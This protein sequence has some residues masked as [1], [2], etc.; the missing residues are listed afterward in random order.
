MIRN[1]LPSPAPSRPSIV[2]A[3]DPNLQGRVPTK[4]P[5]SFPR[6]P[7]MNIS[8]NVWRCRCILF[9]GVV[10]YV[11][12]HR[13]I[14]VHISY[15]VQYNSTNRIAAT[16][17]KHSQNIHGKDSKVPSLPSSFHRSSDSS[18]LGGTC[19]Q[20]ILGLD[21]KDSWM[22]DVSIHFIWC[23]C[24]SSKELYIHSSIRNRYK[25]SLTFQITPPSLTIPKNPCVFPMG[26]LCCARR[27]LDCQW[28]ES[29]HLSEGY[30]PHVAGRCDANGFH[31][32]YSDTINWM[33]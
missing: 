24:V 3:Q 1:G 21:V 9:D 18:P 6:F 31:E 19:K 27:P 12:I 14:H 26:T 13:V 25:I 22:L 20:V 11:Y 8:K 15:Y 30:D 29:I 33:D 17:N 16:S 10:S 32:N 4:L 28:P 23:W 2:I 5:V 7:E